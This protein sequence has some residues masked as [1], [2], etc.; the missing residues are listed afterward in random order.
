MA[1]GLPRAGLPPSHRMQRTAQRAGYAPHTS[2]PEGQD[3]AT[4]LLHSC[5]LPRWFSLF[6]HRDPGMSQLGVG[7]T[8][9]APSSR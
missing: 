9:P 6:V 2:V 4:A 8:G 3:A 1:G 5:A 7:L